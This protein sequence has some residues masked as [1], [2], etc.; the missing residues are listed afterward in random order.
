MRIL[1]EKNQSVLIRRLS[2]LTWRLGS[3]V[4]LSLVNFLAANLNLFN[5]QPQLVI[6]LSL[7]LGE[8]TK[9]LN[10]K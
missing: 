6:V 4:A 1:S 10:T 9:A 5:L 3:L 2:S 8:V 7:I